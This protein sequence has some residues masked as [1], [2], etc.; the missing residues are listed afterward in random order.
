MQTLSRNPSL[1]P[2]T[3]LHY[4]IIKTV[5]I[6]LVKNHNTAF[7]KLILIIVFHEKHE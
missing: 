5:F 6:E 4:C 7:Y 2:F 1:D 3:H